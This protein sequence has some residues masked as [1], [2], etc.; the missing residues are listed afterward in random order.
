MPHIIEVSDSTYE[1]FGG[2]AKPFETPENLLI[3]FMESWEKNNGK[4][5]ALEPKSGDTM[6][7]SI[8]PRLTHAKLLKVKVLNEIMASPTWAKLLWDMI[9]RIPKAQLATDEEARKL[10]IIPFV[11]GEKVDDGYKF[12]QNRGISIQNQDSNGAWKAI[13]YLAKQLGIRVEVEFVWRNKDGAA[14]PG[15]VGRLS[16]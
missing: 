10:I 15:K 9:Q 4:D 13:S 7:F 8:A 14:Y 3:R 2:Y 11:R 1:R 16:A 6:E 12:I 5:E